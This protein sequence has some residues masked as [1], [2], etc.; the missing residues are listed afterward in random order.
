MIYSKRFRFL[1]VHVYKTA[2]RSI[3]SAL[4][5][6]LKKRSLGIYNKLLNRAYSEY[7]AHEFAN[8]V[9]PHASAACIRNEL[10]AEEWNKLFSFAFVRNPWDMQV[11]LYNF[12]LKDKTHFQHDLISSMSSFDEYIEWRCSNN[13]KLQKKFVCDNKGNLLVDFLG[14]FENLTKDFEYINKRVN[15]DEELPHLNL[16]N[17]T[18]YRS[19]YNN[20]TREKIE[21]HYAEDIDFFNYKF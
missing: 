18:D 14:K 17:A 4:E 13:V 5:N 19:Y 9:N 20:A 1:F 2:G 7:K 11:S 16:S 3:E 12:M 10:G 15:M 8:S 21:T 6:F